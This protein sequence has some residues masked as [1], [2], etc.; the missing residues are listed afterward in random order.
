MQRVCLRIS[1]LLARPAT[2]SSFIYLVDR[3]NFVGFTTTITEDLVFKPPKCFANTALQANIDGVRESF[4]A[5]AVPRCKADRSL[6]RPIALII[7]FD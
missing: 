1:S 4:E 3:G 2:G 5:L 7:Y 6:L